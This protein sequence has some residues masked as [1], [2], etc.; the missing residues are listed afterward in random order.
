M[1]PVS[2][3]PA[4]RLPPSARRRLGA[5]AETGVWSA[6]TAPGQEAALR[7]VG[8]EPAGV[9]TASVPSWPF[10]YR[11]PRAL[12]HRPAASASATWVPPDDAWATAR[13]GGFSRDYARRDGGGVI[14]DTGWSWQRVVFELRQRQLFAAAIDQLRAQAAALGAQGVVGVEAQWL[15]RQ[16]MYWGD[17]RVT[18]LR[19]VA[20]AVRCPGAP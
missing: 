6:G 14:P 17:F 8:L 11:Y 5:A 16:E 9:V 19:A 10:P 12:T 2:E 20:T 4:A 3:P 15:D 13:M 1:S 18:E 7:S